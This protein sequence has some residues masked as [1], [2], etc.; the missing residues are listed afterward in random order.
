[1]RSS[2]HHCA[3]PSPL[4][5]HRHHR[6]RRTFV[7][8]GR[9]VDVTYAVMVIGEQPSTRLYSQ[10]SPPFVSCLLSSLSSTPQCPVVLS[11]SYG[12]LPV[13]NSVMCERIYLCRH[14]SSSH[15]RRAGAPGTS[16]LHVV[17]GGWHL[18]DMHPGER[19]N[20]PREESRRPIALKSSSGHG[21]TAGLGPNAQRVRSLR[22]LSV[23]VE[24]PPA[25]QSQVLI[26]PKTLD[27]GRWW[28]RA[29]RPPR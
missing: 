13:Q 15:C 22:G 3:C 8:V 2:F 14:S 12:Q 5:P 28:S 23:A 7:V 19:A 27:H 6:R 21:D 25:P 9:V 1:M 29:A 16:T 10:L 4:S 24:A 11:L 18:F 20:C 26:G 17:G